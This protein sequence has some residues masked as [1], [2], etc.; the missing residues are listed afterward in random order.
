MPK[1]GGGGGGGRGEGGGRRRRRCW[2]KSPTF[3]AF[4]AMAVSEGDAL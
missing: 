2:R 1:D 4:T 3:T